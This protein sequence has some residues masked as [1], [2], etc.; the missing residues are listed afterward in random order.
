MLL[1]HRFPTQLLL[2]GA[3]SPFGWRLIKFKSLTSRS[4]CNRGKDGAE[5]TGG[6]RAGGEQARIVMAAS[7]SW[8][9]R[10]LITK[11]VLR[12]SKTLLFQ[13][14]EDGPRFMFCGFDFILFTKRA[15]RY[16]F[17]DLASDVLRLCA[18][19]VS[20]A[21]C[22]SNSRCFQMSCCIEGAQWTS[23]PVTAAVKVRGEK[24]PVAHVARVL[25]WQILTGEYY[26]LGIHE[27]DQNTE[28]E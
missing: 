18:G 4:S 1:V 7:L 19:H 8:C 23:Q 27:K 28:R 9:H 25:C 21:M 13:S 6:G 22:W 2:L 14:A 10:P 3:T 26:K 17:E 11:V 20:H 24:M 16:L 5:E 15:G 12:R